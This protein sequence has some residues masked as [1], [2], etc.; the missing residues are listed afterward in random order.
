MG[1]WGRVR[2][3]VVAIFAGLAAP[4]AASAMPDLRL[5]KVSPRDAGRQGLITPT[6][7]RDIVAYVEISNVSAED[8]PAMIVLC[9]RSTPG[10]ATLAEGAARADV[11]PRGR[12]VTVGLGVAGASQ[13]G[14]GRMWCK[15]DAVD[16]VPES[17]EANN[18]LTAD[19]TVEEDG[20]ADFRVGVRGGL[21]PW[22]TEPQGHRRVAFEIF[23]PS[24][25]GPASATPLEVRERLRWQFE[26]TVPQ[27]PWVA[28]RETGNMTHYPGGDV[29]G[30]GQGVATSL[31]LDPVNLSNHPPASGMPAMLTLQ[32][33]VR[34]GAFQPNVPV[35]HVGDSLP[36]PDWGSPVVWWSENVTLNLP[37]PE[38]AIR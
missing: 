7:G 4:A 10:S 28:V 24:R 25:R 29:P 9:R 22:T 30:A 20:Y 17:N 23:N 38:S 14:A 37:N 18:E 12:T 1:R 27:M 33:T 21:R 6:A 8:A 36:R 32:C 11:I 13:P 19:F 31:W 3:A 15:V 26:C 5:T 2:V 16:N 34:V 35:T